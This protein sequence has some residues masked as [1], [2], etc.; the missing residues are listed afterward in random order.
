MKEILFVKAIPLRPFS[1]AVLAGCLILS[2]MVSVPV[3]AQ[4]RS[5]AHDADIVAI[6]KTLTEV[7]KTQKEIIENQEEILSVL[8][9][10]KIWVRRN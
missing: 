6:Q 7:Q 10:M 5:G 3:F 9:N 8:E 2:F 4:D 1:F